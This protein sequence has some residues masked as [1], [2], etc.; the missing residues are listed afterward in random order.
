MNND[1]CKRIDSDGNN[2]N[3]ASMKKSTHARN[4]QPNNPSTNIYTN[5]DLFCSFPM[6]YSIIINCLL[7]ELPCSTGGKGGGVTE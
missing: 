1:E 6:N 4:S 5:T 3:N 2:N 7:I